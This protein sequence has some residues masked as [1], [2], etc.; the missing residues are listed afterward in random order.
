MYTYINYII[1]LR[2]LLLIWQQPNQ[3]RRAQVHFEFKIYLHDCAVTQMGRKR[4]LKR[5]LV[6]P[7]SFKLP[8]QKVESPL[9][10]VFSLNYI[11]GGRYLSINKLGF[12]S[13][14]YGITATRLFLAFEFRVRAYH[15]FFC[16]KLI[17]C[18]HYWWVW[19][20]ILTILYNSN[21]V[22]P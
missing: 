18:F 13:Y 1:L 19:Y 15:E 21:V 14:T 16:W 3:V 10:F 22:I 9:Q 6:F 11:A 20:S 5:V 8:V 4:L 17:F 7:Y 12:L 2:R